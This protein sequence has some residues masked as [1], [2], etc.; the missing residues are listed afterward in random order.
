MGPFFVD[1]APEAINLGTGSI[2]WYSLN[3]YIQEHRRAASGLGKQHHLARLDFARFE[4]LSE[5]DYS[6]NTQCL[7]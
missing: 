3:T 5:S 7:L 6:S 1:C 2:T 4:K